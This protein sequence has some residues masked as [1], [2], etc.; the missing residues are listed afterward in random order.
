MVKEQPFKCQ[1]PYKIIENTQQWV[2]IYVIIVIFS[3]LWLYKM[4]KVYN[5]KNWKF[6]DYKIVQHY[7]EM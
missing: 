3:Y 2:M 6:L 1:I 7:T 5:F 4:C